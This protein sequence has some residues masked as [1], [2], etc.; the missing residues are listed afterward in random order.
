[1][2][3]VRRGNTEAMSSQDPILRFQRFS[4]GICAMVTNLKGIQAK[5][6]QSIQQSAKCNDRLSGSSGMLVSPGM[7]LFLSQ[8]IQNNVTLACLRALCLCFNQW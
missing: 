2:A 5:F 6:S 8:D 4:K 3:T 7:G 1:M